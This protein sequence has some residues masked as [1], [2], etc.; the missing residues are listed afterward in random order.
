MKSRDGDKVR[1]NRVERTARNLSF[2][3]SALINEDEE[4]SLVKQSRIE[5]KYR[6][7]EK[8]IIESFRRKIHACLQANEDL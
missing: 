1:L 2:P 3:W 4:K 7:D 5:E 6:F 8:S